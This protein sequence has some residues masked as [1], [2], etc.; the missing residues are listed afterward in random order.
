MGILHDL[1]LLLRRV[2]RPPRTRA[3]LDRVQL[4]SWRAASGGP[5]P[6]R[7]V[8]RRYFH[9]N[10]R[11]CHVLEHLLVRKDDYDYA[12]TSRLHLRR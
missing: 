2:D 8:G 9:G 3:L 5:T 7:L 6:G 4:R 1:H 11:C 12:Q 10:P